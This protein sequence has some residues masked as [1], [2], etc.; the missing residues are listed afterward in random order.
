M[1]DE[2]YGDLAIEFYEAIATVAKDKKLAMRDI[3]IAMCICIS[4]MTMEH[5]K[6]L[7][8]DESS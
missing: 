4:A 7:K 2:Q 8:E 3:Y 1:T 6:S 5:Q